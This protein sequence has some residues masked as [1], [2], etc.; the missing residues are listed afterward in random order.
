EDLR[1]LEREIVQ[2]D[3]FRPDR[4][5]AKRLRTVVGSAGEC[6][7]KIGHRCFSSGVEKKTVGV[8]HG[9]VKPVNAAAPLSLESLCDKA[10]NKNPT[11]PNPMK[12]PPSSAA[13]A[14]APAEP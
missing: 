12:S 1:R 6:Q 4:A 3:A 14:P 11:G 10:S 7:S 5:V 8:R 9:P 13:R 2:L